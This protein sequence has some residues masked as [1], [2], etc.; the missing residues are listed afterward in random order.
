MRPAP[1]F[2]AWNLKNV[3]KAPARN[4]DGAFAPTALA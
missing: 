4:M 1:G 2:L 3:F